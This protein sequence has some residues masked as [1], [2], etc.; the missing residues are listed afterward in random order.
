MISNNSAEELHD[1]LYSSSSRA[2]GE[3]LYKD[4][5]AFPSLF[6]R[7][8]RGNP[9]PLHPVS[10][11][12]LSLSRLEARS[13]QSK[14]DMWTWRRSGE[15]TE[16]CWAPDASMPCGGHEDSCHVFTSPPWSQ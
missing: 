5:A 2:R 11:P 1:P 12:P 10:N 3:S 4:S 14:V 13:D 9:L 6:T 7:L 16:R 8:D 15:D